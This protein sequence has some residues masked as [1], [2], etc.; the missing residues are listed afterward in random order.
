MLAENSGGLWPSRIRVDRGV[1]NVP[2]LVIKLKMNEFWILLQ[3]ACHTKVSRASRQLHVTLQVWL[4]HCIA[5]VLCDWLELVALFSFNDT[6][7]TAAFSFI[8]FEVESKEQDE[9]KH[10]NSLFG[11]IFIILSV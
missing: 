2:K 7:E 9:Y 11:K 3:L 5:Y 6:V 10:C 4:D 8:F 1:E